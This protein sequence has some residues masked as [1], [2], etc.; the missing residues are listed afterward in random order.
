MKIAAWNVNSVRARLEHLTRWLEEC[1]PDVL[2]LQETKCREED[3]PQ[4]E[5][6]A[7]GY[8]SV[9]YG[10]P[11]YNGVAIL[12]RSAPADVARG[13][14]AR[15]DDAQARVIAAT[16][17]G[18]RVVSAYVPNGQSVGSE[19]YAYKL[20]WLADFAD[21]VAAF[22]DGVTVVGGDY[23]IAPAAADIFDAEEWGEGILA[24]PA[25]RAALAEVLGRGYA[26]AHRLFVQPEGLFSW[27]DYRAA[28]FRRNRGVRIDLMLVSAAAARR[29]VACAPDVGPRGWERPSDHAP[30]VLTLD[31]LD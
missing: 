24:S 15:A 6:R 12:S 5:M 11:A 26:D 23:N 7:R 30:V 18:V 10:Q 25:E 1:A 22:A 9:H 16:V 2:L 8:F 4:A 28:A 14:P 3:F 21:Y 29:A 13:M 17:D 20:A 27:W 31:S 19:K